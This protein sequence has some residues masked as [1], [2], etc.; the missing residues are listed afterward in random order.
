[1]PSFSAY[2]AKQWQIQN[3]PGKVNDSPNKQNIMFISIHYHSTLS[4]ILFRLCEMNETQGSS[5]VNV[6][7]T[8]TAV[9]INV[10]T[11]TAISNDSPKTVF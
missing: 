2:G 1:M 8:D 3:L 7:L 5:H 6:H 10:L 11:L 9:Y 4:A